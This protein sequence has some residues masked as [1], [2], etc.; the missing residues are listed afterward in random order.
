VFELAH[1]AEGEDYELVAATTKEGRAVLGG[2]G[3]R[4]RGDPWAPV[5]VE[6][7]RLS[8]RGRPLKRADMPMDPSSRALFMRDG[9]VDVVG[10]LLA[11][12]GELLGL[13]C[14]DARLVLFNP[15]TLAGVL[16]ADRAEFVLFPS[17]GRIMAITKVMLHSAALAG[18]GAFRLAEDPRGRL[19]VASWLVDAVVAT[20]MSSGTGFKLVFDSDLADGIDLGSWG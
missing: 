14:P 3:L 5:E 7:W 12:H 20:G 18:V 8:E 11:P 9:A 17:S 2:L 4:R 15:P 13:S 16:D 19:Y 10:P 6:L 1:T